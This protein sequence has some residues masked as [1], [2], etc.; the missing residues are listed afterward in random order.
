MGSVQIAGS[1]ILSAFLSRRQPED[2]EAPQ[3][4]AGLALR[5]LTARDFGLAIAVNWRSGP[6]LLEAFYAAVGGMASCWTGT[7]RL[8]PAMNLSNSHPVYISLYQ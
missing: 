2:H 5:D 7:V 1:F 4:V 3:R 6:G 8:L